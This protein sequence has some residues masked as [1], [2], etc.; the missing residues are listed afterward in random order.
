VAQ[1]RAAAVARARRAAAARQQEAMTPRF[2]RDLLGNLV[3]DVRAAAA[4][5]FDPATGEVLWE[6]N[7][8]DQRSIASITKVMTALVFLADEPD[9]TQ[10]VAV[11]AADVRR[12]SVTYLR[13]AEKVSYKDLLHL[14]L[15]SSDN[16]AA[17]VLARTS[18]GGTKA[19]VGRM[20]DMAH[21]LN[22]TTTQFA[23]SSGLDSNNLSSAYDVSQ[24]I[25][26][27]AGEPLLA[28]IMGTEEYV[29]QAGGR[30]IPI[31]STNKLLSSG[32]DVRAGKT[33]F[34]RKA[35]YCLATLLQMPQGSPVAVVV[36]G[37][38]N[39]TARFWETRHL[40]NWVV[41]RTPALVVG[42]N[43]E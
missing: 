26:F 34:I 3:P 6:A 23:D 43:Q 27:A 14:M 24:L 36:L 5:V 28:S 11:A 10:Q 7:A 16:G 37:A 31:H 21:H 15:I 1:S 12:A 17:R 18:E 40:F 20:N 4:I 29:A 9:L 22:L 8:K 25:A 39:S 2:K 19:F 13:P 32:F 38:A 30:R 33:G 35:G 41:E 42:Q